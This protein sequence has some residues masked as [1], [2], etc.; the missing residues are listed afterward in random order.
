MIKLGGKF[1]HGGKQPQPAWDRTN[2]ESRK[3]SHHARIGNDRNGYLKV[4][5]TWRLQDLKKCMLV[6]RQRSTI[7]SVKQR[8]KR[9][10]SRSGVREGEK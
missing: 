4:Y 6:E 2:F 9:S 1:W 8:Q 5:K 3:A 10:A 7:N